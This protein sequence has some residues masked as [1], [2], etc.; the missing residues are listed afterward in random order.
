M[1]EAARL[2]LDLLKK[3]V[4]NFIYD[5]LDLMRAKHGLDPVSGKYRIAQAAASEPHLKYYGAI[6]PSRAH[7]MIGIPRLDN[8]Q[9]CVEAVN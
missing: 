9:F 5:D 7:T 6:W 4:S 3:C 1:R 2:Y 8:L